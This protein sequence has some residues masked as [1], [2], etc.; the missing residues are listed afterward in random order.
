MTKHATVMT[1]VAAG[2]LLIAGCGAGGTAPAPP[3][4]S[5]G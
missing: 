1:T 3:V 4:E 2:A 5:A